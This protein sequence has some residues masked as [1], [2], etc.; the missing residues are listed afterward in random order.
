MPFVLP[1]LRMLLREIGHFCNYENPRQGPGE[2][3]AHGQMTFHRGPVPWCLLPLGVY[4]FPG[5]RVSSSPAA[6]LP[7]PCW[8]LPRIRPHYTRQKGEGVAASRRRAR[9]HQIV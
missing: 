5:R 7:A 9:L 8:L 6:L 4:C 1:P 2:P 3:A